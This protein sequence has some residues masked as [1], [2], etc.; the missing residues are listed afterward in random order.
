MSSKGARVRKSSKTFIALEGF[1]PSVRSHMDLVLVLCI[2]GIGTSFTKPVFLILV[3]GFFMCLQTRHLV[4]NVVTQIATELF[5][6]MN[7]FDMK[8]QSVLGFKSFVALITFERAQYV[9]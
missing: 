3:D 6:F 8:F 1:L 7:R 9:Y 2:T 5:F 4:C